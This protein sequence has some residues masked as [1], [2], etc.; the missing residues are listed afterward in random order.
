MDAEVEG[1]RGDRKGWHVSWCCWRKQAVLL[2]NVV[3]VVGVEEEVEVR[4]IR[5]VRPR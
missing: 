5:A 4:L 3:S 2:R 1:L